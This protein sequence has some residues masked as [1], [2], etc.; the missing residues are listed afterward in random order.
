MANDSKG[1]RRTLSIATEQSGSP[2][3]P[4]RTVPGT[5]SLVSLIEQPMKLLQLPE[6]AFTSLVDDFIAQG[7]PLM[8]AVRRGAG[9]LA[10]AARHK[11]RDGE[12]GPWLHRLAEELGQHEDSVIRWRDQVTS[13]MGLPVPAATKERSRA[14]LAGA[15]KAVRRAGEKLA[16]DAISAGNVVELGPL[17]PAPARDLVVRLL[18]TPAAELA[19]SATTDELR[20]LKA[21]I[22]DALAH[23]HRESLRARTAERQRRTT[24]T[25]S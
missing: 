25:G 14:R 21:L 4:A 9:I 5:P 8:K 22:D 10:W 20:D 19:A 3:L 6:T 12:Y 16:E 24:R 23:Q 11:L 17:G 18:A 7:A 15:A 1:G 13:E 2:L